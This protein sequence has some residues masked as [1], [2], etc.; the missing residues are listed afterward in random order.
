MNWRLVTRP[1]DRASPARHARRARQL[2]RL[3][4]LPHPRRRP[5]WLIYT[6]VKRF[7]GNFKDAHNYLVTAPAIT[8]PWSD[9][10]YLNSSGFDP[11]LFHDDDGRKWLLNMQWKHLTE[12]VGG[13]PKRLRLRRH[14]RPG[15]RP[16]ARRL[17]GPIRNI[18]PG[19]PHGLVEGPHLFKRDGW[20]YL[21]TAEGGTGYDHAVT[22]ARSR[23]LLGPYELHP[24]TFLLTSKDAP[25]APLQRAGHGQIVETPEALP[26]TP[27]S[28]AARCPA[29]ALPA[30]PRDR[31]QQCAWGDDG[32]LRLDQ[33]G[34][35]RRSRFPRPPARADPAPEARWNT[36]STARRC[37]KTSSGCAPPTPSA[38]SP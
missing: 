17:T 27:T 18:F 30:R 6:D 35:C 8:G 38:S 7:D 2:R 22:M 32:W 3:G 25:D 11:S 26:T 10:I 34:R 9:P 12:S 36:A 1:L 37:R 16:R 21:T 28:A 13:R 23:T 31:D 19:S 20:Y 14:P 15:I 29:R 24:D 5:F 4:P 33:G